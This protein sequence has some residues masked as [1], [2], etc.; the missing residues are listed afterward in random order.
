MSFANKLR[1]S[2]VRRIFAAIFVTA[3]LMG[4]FSFKTYEAEGLPV[5]TQRV[6]PTRLLFVGDMMFDRHIRQVTDAKGGDY[7]FLCADETL[8]AYDAVVGNLEGPITRSESKSLG[9]A[10]GSPENYVFTFPLDTAKLLLRHNI[11]IV[12]LG[13]NHIYNFESEGLAETRRALKTVGVGYFGGVEGDSTVYRSV[14]NGKKFSF[15][16]FNEFGGDDATTTTAQIVTEKAAGR[17]VIVYAH[18]G[19][20]YVDVPV[21]VRNWTDLFLDSG[22]DAIIGS[23]P[24]VVQGWGVRGGKP[25]YYSL[26]NFIFDQYFDADVT[27][28]LAVELVFDGTEVTGREFDVRIHQDGRSCIGN[29]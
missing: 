12:N 25:Y 24:H 17:A 23:H 21:R 26:G 16:N 13:N 9:S 14:F 18:W 7:L 3:L 4:V 28:G 6:Q 8:H 22:A 1:S 11:S 2:G 10:V 29:F 19:D 5:L 15:V 20:E 27:R